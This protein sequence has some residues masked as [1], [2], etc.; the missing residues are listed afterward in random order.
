MPARY[1]S[2]QRNGEL[3]PRAEQVW[4]MLKECRLCPHE[5]GVNRLAGEIGVCQTGE[6]AVVASF[7]PHY[8]EETPL[9]GVGGSGTVFF[10][11]CNLQCCFCQNYEISQYAEGR[12]ASYEDLAAM[13]LQLQSQGCHN[14]NFV[15]PSHVVAQIMMALAIA[16]ERGLRVPLVYNCGGYD[17]VETLQLLAGVFDIYMPDMKYANDDVAW[18]LSGIEDYVAVNHAAVRE[19]HRQ[20][21]VLTTDD[22]GVATQ[23]V[24]IRHLVLPGGLAGTGEMAEF[25][26]REISPDTF[27]NLMDQYRPAYLA[28]DYPHLDRRLTEKEYQEAL[29]R[30]REAGLHNFASGASRIDLMEL[31]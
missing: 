15:S 25:L 29:A 23:G 18:H 13:M 24:I 14:I 7:N 1:L 2:L 3:R 19:M 27:V 4:Q 30:A 21:G 8:G 6:R 9:V 31:I 22:R 10:A 12:S 28:R 17:R 20:V 26:V 16:A 5:C 11:H